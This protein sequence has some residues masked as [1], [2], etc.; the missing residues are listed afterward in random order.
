MG[1]F[2]KADR[3]NELQLQVLRNFLSYLVRVGD[4]NAPFVF[5]EKSFGELIHKAYYDGD[6]VSHAALKSYGVKVSSERDVVYLAKNNNNLNA[7][8]D[9][10]YGDN[11]HSFLQGNHQVKNAGIVKFGPMKVYGCIEVSLG[12]INSLIV[13]LKYA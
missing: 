6:E 8:M 3:V 10:L 13:E 7:V 2:C 4:S 12:L 11:W 5:K 1:E 9:Y